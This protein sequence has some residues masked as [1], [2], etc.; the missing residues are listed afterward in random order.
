MKKIA[1][2]LL[3]ALAVGCGQANKAAE[4]STEQQTVENV[5]SD[6][7]VVYEHDYLV[8]VGD[9]APDFTLKIDS[10]TT[11]ISSVLSS[12]AIAK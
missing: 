12:M 5:K 10:A 8:K 6:S 3:S 4:S 9:I 1:L 11:I 2:I 7:T